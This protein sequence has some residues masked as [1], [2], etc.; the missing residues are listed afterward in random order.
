M[1]KSSSA[2]VP[3]VLPTGAELMSGPIPKPAMSRQ[4]KEIAFVVNNIFIRLKKGE[5]EEQYEVRKG[6]FFCWGGLSALVAV[7]LILQGMSETVLFSS[8]QQNMTEV[9]I[10]CCLFIPI[11]LWAFYILCPWKEERARRETI[12]EQVRERKD[13]TLFNSMVDKAR[14]S[15][16][17]PVI[18]VK[19]IAKLRKVDYAITAHN[20]KEFQELLEVKTGLPV[21]RQLIKYQ[22][23]VLE[24][25][26]EQRLQ[27][28]MHFANNT[29][30]FIYN[31]VSC[32]P[33]F[34]F[35]FLINLICFSSS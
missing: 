4:E 18:K 33:I 10:G 8:Q 32:S 15:S 21:A 30:F 31:I 9:A 11:L 6:C 25:R 16:K 29:R 1:K 20:M 12:K 3:F 13:P 7:F 22:D 34:F 24:F 14:E 28:D 17:P 26:P 27:E 5:L 2:V 23:E 19:I 35:F